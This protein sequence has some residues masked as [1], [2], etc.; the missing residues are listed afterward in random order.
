MYIQNIQIQT[1]MSFLFDTTVY[2][3]IYPLTIKYIYRYICI[4]QQ[5]KGYMTTLPEIT[6]GTYYENNI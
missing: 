6:R 2:I 4:Q 5:K 3:Y 1:C